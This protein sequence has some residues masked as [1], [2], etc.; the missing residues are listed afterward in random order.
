MYVRVGV[1]HVV[2]D[3][4]CVVAVFCFPVSMCMHTSDDFPPALTA[5]NR[6]GGNHL[7]YMYLV[8]LLW[9]Q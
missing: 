8:L 2:H 1:V 4:H 5:P 7:R 6:A 3:V 9:Y